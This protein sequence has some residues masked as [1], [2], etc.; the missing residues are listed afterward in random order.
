MEQMQDA[1]CTM[2]E[3]ATSVWFA[4]AEAELLDV[5]G[6][7][8][9]DV[10]DYS[11]LGMPPKIVEATTESRYKDSPNEVG[12]LGHRMAWASKGIH[13]IAYLADYPNADERRERI[14][15]MLRATSNRAI[16]MRRELRK[17]QYANWDMDAK[18]T[19]EKAFNLLAGL[20][21]W[22]HRRP[23]AIDRILRGG[24]REEVEHARNLEPEIAAAAERIA[25]KR[26]AA[27]IRATRRW[28]KLATLGEAHKATKLTSYTGIKSASASKL[29]QGERTRQEAADKGLREWREPWQGEDFDGGESIARTIEAVYAVGRKET[30]Y[31]ESLLP[32]FEIDRVSYFASKFKGNTGRGSNGARPPQLQVTNQRG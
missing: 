23:P 16:A 4:G 6:I 18:H 2:L 21:R 1:D 28:A 7:S 9:G 32:D 17:Q 19:L 27:E 30:E 11:G 5:M 3:H 15:C 12:L 22:V 8:D 20:N 24:G 31:E 14:E 29:H 25:T 13:Y 26:R 10:G